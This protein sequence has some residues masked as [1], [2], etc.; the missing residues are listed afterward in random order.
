MLIAKA[1]FSEGAIKLVYVLF[2]TATVVILDFMSFRGIASDCLP[3][4]FRANLQHIMII[5]AYMHVISPCSVLHTLTKHCKVQK[6]G[7]D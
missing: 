2:R 4:P 7:E 1:V 5:I 6:N 3:N